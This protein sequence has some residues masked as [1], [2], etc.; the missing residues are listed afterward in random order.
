[1]QDTEEAHTR[2]AICARRSVADS[3]GI[4]IKFENSRALAATH[5]TSRWSS[6]TR[7]RRLE[8]IAHDSVPTQWPTHDLGSAEPRCPECGVVMRLE[9]GGW[10]GP[11]CGR[12]EHV[13][14]MEMSPISTPGIHGGLRMPG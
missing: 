10:R 8:V 13:E 3:E 11:E 6:S 2:A 7:L 5:T 12:V 9:R 4:G 14:Q 1:M